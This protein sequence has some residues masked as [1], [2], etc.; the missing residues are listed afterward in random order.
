MSDVNP[1]IYWH[2]V[3]DNIE[4]PILVIDN[5]GASL[6]GHRVEDNGKLYK[7]MELNQKNM[8]EHFD[9]DY[10]AG[11]EAGV[12]AMFKAV[13]WEKIDTYLKKSKETLL[14][15]KASLSGR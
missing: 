14:S 9:Y 1:T 8:T 11:F 10:K 6:Y 7:A 5:K 13:P 12:L 15:M 4:D 2:P 3:S